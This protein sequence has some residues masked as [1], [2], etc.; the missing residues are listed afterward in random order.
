[1]E[2]KERSRLFRRYL[3][4]SLPFVAVPY[5][6]TAF[7]L[8]DLNVSHWSGWARAICALLTLCFMVFAGT[9][10]AAYVAY[11]DVMQDGN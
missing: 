5:L 6:F 7:V 11:K 2:G 1:M 4:M 9:M 8:Y 10:V 3:W